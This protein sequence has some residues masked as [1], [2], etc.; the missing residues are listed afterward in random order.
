MST[1]PYQ[2]ANT[3]DLITPALLVFREIVE[4]NLNQMIAIAGDAAR[5]RPHCKTHKMPDVT[6]WELS[7][8]IKKHKAATFAEAE[9]LAEAGVLDVMLAYNMVGANIPRA[10][11]FRQRYPNVGFSVTADH[12]QPLSQLAKA[13][14]EAGCEIDVLIDLDTGQHRTGMPINKEAQKL[15]QLI[16]ETPGVNAGGLHIYDG[17]NHQENVAEP[18]SRRGY[19][20]GCRDRFPR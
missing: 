7:L 5:L 3:T 15:Y 1:M 8:G 18:P 4:E 11:L 20:L 10:V 16:D 6:K 14:R 17:Q 2:I 9:M 19:V 12:P 13:M